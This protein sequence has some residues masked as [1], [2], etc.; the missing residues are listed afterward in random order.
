M[1]EKVDSKWFYEFNKLPFELH[2]YAQILPSL[3]AKNSFCETVRNV[4]VL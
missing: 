3:A 2:D 4:F 1:Q